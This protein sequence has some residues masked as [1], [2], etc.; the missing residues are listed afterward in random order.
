MTLLRKRSTLMVCM[1]VV[2]SCGA[3]I[4]WPVYRGKADQRKLFEAAKMCRERAEQGDAHAQVDLTFMYCQGKGV[5]RNYAEAV[6]WSRKAAAQGSAAGQYA[7]GGLYYRGLGVTR[8]YAEA[9]RLYRKAADQGDSNAQ[10]GLAVSYAEGLGVP[11]DY[12]EAVRWARKAADQ[13][14]A[15]AQYAIGSMYRKGQ[16]VPEDYTEAIRWYRKAADQGDGD[17]QYGLGFLY[18]K[19]QGVPR[20][21]TEAVHWYRKAA[22]QGNTNA[23]RALDSMGAGSNT[24]RMVRYLYLVMAFLVNLGASLSFLFARRSLRGSLQKEISFFGVVGMALAG[25]NLYGLVRQDEGHYEYG[26]GFCSGHNLGLLAGMF[27]TMLISVCLMLVSIRRRQNR[28][29]GIA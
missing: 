18:H 22:D 26:Y 15:A 13:G 5:P 3:V 25:V 19:G 4:A 27:I 28:S 14:N 11:Q 7:L 29:S 12:A 6:H 24:A 9:A 20:D 10:Y 2:A 23:L 17:A 16:G 1:T 21:Y 8:D